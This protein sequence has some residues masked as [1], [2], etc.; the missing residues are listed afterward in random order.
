MYAGATETQAAAIGIDIG[1]D[2]LLSG[3]ITQTNESLLLYVF[4]VR[5]RDAVVLAGREMLLGPE[6]ELNEN[7]NIMTK[8]LVS[9]LPQFSE[10]GGSS[11]AANLE[12][13]RLL[14]EI[15]ETFKW[16]NGGKRLSF[17]HSLEMYLA[18]RMVAQDTY[19]ENVVLRRMPTLIEYH[20]NTYSFNNN[21]RTIKQKPEDQKWNNYLLDTL[22]RTLPL[23]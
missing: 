5:S 20:P 4:V 13:A 14:Y 1:A 10:L 15:A 22:T 12:E 7:F 23:P 19:Y 16:R 6:F 2:Y 17:Y 3:A 18:A 8:G 21:W 9:G 11:E